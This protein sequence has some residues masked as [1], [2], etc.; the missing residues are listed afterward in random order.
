MTTPLIILTSLKINLRFSW[1]PQVWKWAWNLDLQVP[2]ENEPLSIWT[3]AKSSLEWVVSSWLSKSFAVAIP[4]QMRRVVGSWDRPWL[5]FENLD[6]KCEFFFKH[7]WLTNCRY[8]RRVYPCAVKNWGTSLPI[9]W[10]PHLLWGGIKE[11][12]WKEKFHAVNGKA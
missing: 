11:Q 10:V 1:V 8:R 4:N 9:E 12:F 6:A 2:S 3:S 7:T 5:N